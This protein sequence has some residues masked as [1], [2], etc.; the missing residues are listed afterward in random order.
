MKIIV[1]SFLTDAYQWFADT[2]LPIGNLSESIWNA[3]V[4][5]IMSYALDSPQDFNRPA[6]TFAIS[7]LFS[8]SKSVGIVLVNL[9]FF[10]NFIRAATNL[11]QNITLEM[12]VEA[13]AKLVF[14][15][16]LMLKLDT[17]IRAITNAT[18]N[19]AGVISVNQSTLTMDIVDLDI[20]WSFTYW[21]IDLV[22]IFIAG[23][24]VFSLIKAFFIRYFDI[25]LL[26]AV[27]PLAISTISG[28]HEIDNTAKA[29]I[30]TFIGKCF[31]VVIM[32]MAL[33]IGG[34]FASSLD[35]SQYIT[36]VEMFANS[37]AIKISHLICMLI[38][39]T[40][41]RSSDEFTRRAFGF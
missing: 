38:I 5:L 7:D 14:A 9:L 21:L 35:L 37:I 16:V 27:A 3:G 25:Y 11:K 4:Q 29:W 8:I 12:C 2:F 33:G 15:N 34:Y 17:A 23:F 10:A 36:A 13:F 39:T 22:G 18:T 28:G 24:C 6:W 30:K 32:L 20:D 1:A 26:I 40:A 41:V 19:F 31:E